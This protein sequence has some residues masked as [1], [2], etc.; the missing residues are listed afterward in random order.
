MLC[1][2]GSYDLIWLALKTLK[3]YEYKDANK[4]SESK[5]ITNA[6]INYFR[7][8]SDQ[9][10]SRSTAIIPYAQFLYLTD[11]KAFM[12]YRNKSN[13]RQGLTTDDY[14]HLLLAMAAKPEIVA[15]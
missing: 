5:D 7:H 14:V 11:Y 1:A 6:L 2:L 15:N 13:S 3:M 4:R 8:H 10:I 12:I 9:Y